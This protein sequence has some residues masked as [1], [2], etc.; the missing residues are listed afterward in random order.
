MKFLKISKINNLYY[1]KKLWN[2]HLIFILDVLIIKTLLYV[3]I[4]KMKETN[5]KN[6]EKYLNM[7][8]NWKELGYRRENMNTKKVIISFFLKSS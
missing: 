4:V 8:K 3:T 1:L 7:Q 6:Y 2:Y 5:F